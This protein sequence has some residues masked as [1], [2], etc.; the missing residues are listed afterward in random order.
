MQVEVKN[1]QERL[2][3]TFIFVTHDQDEALIMSD[4]IAVMNRGRIE[5]LGAPE[6]LYERP[7]TRFVAD[8]LAVRNLLEVTVED[9]SG[10]RVQLRTR[11]GTRIVAVDAAGSRAGAT[12]CVGIRPERMGL[13]GGGDNA[14]PGVLD[15]EIYLGDRTD[16]RVRVGEETLTVAEGAA[17]ARSRKRGDAV[18][19][20]FPADAVLLLQE[21]PR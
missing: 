5:Q 11:G 9:V 10:G 16:W 14:L 20:S 13:T 6:E 2:K 3:T 19:V 4:R 7:R 1:L 21:S 12:L 17:L 18:T 15:D 8:F